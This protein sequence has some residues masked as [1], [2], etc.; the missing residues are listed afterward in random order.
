MDEN[1]GEAEHEV[2]VNLC[3]QEQETLILIKQQ[4]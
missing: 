1:Q 4:N 3:Q 2:Q